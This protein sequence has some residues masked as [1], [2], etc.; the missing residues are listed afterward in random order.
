MNN[1]RAAYLLGLEAE[2]FAS[3]LLRLKGYRILARRFQAAGAE[4]DLVAKR[5]NTL[6][7]V[8]VKARA[9]RDDAL[10]AITPAKLR[11][12]ARGARA[13]LAR[14]G[15]MPEVIRADAILIAPRRLPRHI[16]NIGELPLD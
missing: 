4:I 9:T 10:L 8:E 5:G 6:V 16:V 13:F 7:F 3:M 1:R 14:E 12:M 15:R 2:F 11:Q